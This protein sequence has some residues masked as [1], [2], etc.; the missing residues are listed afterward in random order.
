MVR[1][2]LLIALSAAPGSLLR[3]QFSSSKFRPTPEMIGQVA[4]A[5][6]PA[7]WVNSEP[8]DS[9]D[10]QG[11]VI[12]LRFFTD[13]P[14]STAGLREL[15]RTYQ[16]QGLTG[17]GM[18]APS[19]MPTQTDPEHVRRLAAV[20]GFHFPVGVDSGWQTIN[21]YWVNRADVEAV[22]ATFLIDRK[23]VIRYIQPDGKYD[24]NSRDSYA[25]KQYEV[26][27]KMVQALIAEPLPDAEEA[28]PDSP[29]TVE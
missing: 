20:L 27:E 24:K 28:A 29:D 22:A 9:L 17:V 23:G 10:L 25:K 11:Q 19:P 16:D 6:T 5:W 14:G 12:L 4:P 13:S 7:A 18:Y 1:F 21:S 8:L 3:A 26:M 2:S 15:L